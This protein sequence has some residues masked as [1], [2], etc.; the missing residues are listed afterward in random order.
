MN[1]QLVQMFRKQF[2]QVPKYFASNEQPIILRNEKSG[3]YVNPEDVARRM[4]KVISLHDDVKNP[5]GITLQSTWTDIGLS[6]MAYVEVMVEVERE[7]EIEF[8]DIDVECFRTVND[9][10]EYVAR[11][12]FAV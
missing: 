3:Y 12:F 2:F 8:P 9:A 1:R 5:S 6:D 4:I 10:V 7:F 11:S